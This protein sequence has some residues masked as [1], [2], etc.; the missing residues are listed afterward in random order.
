[1]TEYTIKRVRLIVDGVPH[2]LTYNADVNTWTGE[3]NAPDISSYLQPDNKYNTQLEITNIADVTNVYDAS[4]FPQLGLRVKECTPP[5]ASVHYPLEGEYTQD[6][7][8][9]AIFRLRDDFSGISPDNI[10]LTLDGEPV[11]FTARQEQ[12]GYD[13]FYSLDGLP[14]GQHTFSISCVDND[15]NV[16][17][18][19]TVTFYLYTDRNLKTDWK[20]TDYLNADDLTRIENYTKWIGEML[21]YNGFTT[22]GTHKTWTEQDIPTRSEIDRIR[23]N[24]DNLRTGLVPWREI[25]YNNNVDYEQVNVWEWD[26]KS[27]LAWLQAILKSL[28]YSA[29]LRS[30]EI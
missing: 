23:Q 29:E 5:T 24:I 22:N 11:A 27:L 10:T 4:T 28:F 3:F 13:V 17:N 6:Y 16:S 8:M 18:T 19:A 2:E 14:D 26:L 15:D 9:T 20:P 12:N 25:L 21:K 30:G 1:M 7:N